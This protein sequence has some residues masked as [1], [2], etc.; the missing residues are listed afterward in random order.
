MVARCQNQRSNVVKIKRRIFRAAVRCGAGRNAIG[1]DLVSDAARD[2]LL[3]SRVGILPA[4]IPSEVPRKIFYPI[5]CNIPGEAPRAIPDEHACKNGERKLLRDWLLL[6]NGWLSDKSAVKGCV[7]EGLMG[8]QTLL[9]PDEL[10]EDGLIVV[11]WIRAYLDWGRTSLDLAQRLARKKP[12]GLRNNVMLILDGL[13]DDTCIATFASSTSSC[14]PRSAS[15]DSSYYPR[16][17]ERPPW[18][19]CDEIYGERRYD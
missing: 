1:E 16:E 4:R 15:V 5:P 13:S 10:S 9:P 3:G 14:P 7:M 19:M 6:A 8:E 2:R 12:P 17:A 11:L 18:I